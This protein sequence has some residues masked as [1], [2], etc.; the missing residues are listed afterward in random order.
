MLLGKVDRELVDN[1]S[2]ISAQRTEKSAISIHDDEAKFL[3]R[4]EQLAQ[5]L[6]MEFVVAKI[7]RRID[8]L[9]GL[10]V[11]VDLSFFSF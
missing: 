3:I 9:E 4:L 2:G 11:N 1:F 8:W 10:E 7:E 5:R 6:R